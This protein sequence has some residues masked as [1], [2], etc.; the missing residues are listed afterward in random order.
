MGGQSLTVKPAEA[1]RRLKGVARQAVTDDAQASFRKISEHR[2]K[3]VHFFHELDA[4]ETEK[5]RATVVGEQCVAWY[6]L[7][8]LLDAW[9][10]EFTEFKNQKWRVQ[11]K[12]KSNRQYLQAVFDGL[13]PEIKREKKEGCTYQD[14]SGCGFP[15]A[16][17]VQLS[18]QVG[19]LTCKVCRMIASEVTIECPSCEKNTLLDHGYLEARACKNKKCGENITSE[20]IERALDQSDPQGIDGFEINCS[21]CGSGNCGVQH[22]NFC[23]CT[24]CLAIE[25]DWGMCEWCNSVEIGGNLGEFSYVGGCGF[26]DGRAG[27]DD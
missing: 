25:I 11:L 21:E 2:N 15:A 9:S 23:I 14:C 17:L 3:L 26:C 19:E 24:N 27:W 12:M 8:R 20:D 5:L 13:S 18:E 16:K 4:A 10:E 1:I 7:E 22:E 6:H